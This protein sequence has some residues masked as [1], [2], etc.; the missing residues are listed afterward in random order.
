MSKIGKKNITV[1][2]ESSVKIE[3]SNLT[4]SGPKG[5]KKLTINDKIFSSK[6]NENQLQIQ[7]L[8]K[9]V[10][11]KT[12]IM[13]FIDPE[14]PQGGVI[15]IG[16]LNMKDAS[17]TQLGRREDG[18]FKPL[19]NTEDGF[20]FEAGPNA[21]SLTP[22]SLE[23]SNVNTVHTLVKFIDHTRSFEM[24]TKIIREMKDNDTSGAAMMRLS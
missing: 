13:W 10:D 18:L 3:G 20:D 15:A 24:Q 7:P 4:I 21:A 1:P 16:R 19:N 17:E 23:G 2:K 8:M 5:S 11:K 9:K 6:L 12:S 22:G 14:D